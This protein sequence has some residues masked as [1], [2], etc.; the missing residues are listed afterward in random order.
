MTAGSRWVH[1]LRN[2]NPAIR[3]GACAAC[4]PVAIKRGGT[5]GTAKGQGKGQ[6]VKQRWKCMGKRSL[7]SR[8]SPTKAVP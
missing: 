5:Y 6:G 4:G 8:A 3:Q 2:I 1:R 7:S